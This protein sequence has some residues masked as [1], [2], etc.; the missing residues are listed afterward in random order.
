[1]AEVSDRITSLITQKVVEVMQAGSNAEM[2]RLVDELAPV[3]DQELILQV[4]TSDAL[5]DPDSPASG[6]SR[7]V[8]AITG[9]RS[10]KNPVRLRFSESNL[11][12]GRFVARFCRSQEGVAPKATLSRSFAKNRVP[13][14]HGTESSSTYLVV[15]DGTRHAESGSVAACG[16]LELLVQAWTVKHRSLHGD[17]ANIPEQVKM[18]CERQRELLELSLKGASANAPLFS[19]SP[20]LLDWI[21]RLRG[22]RESSDIAGRSSRNGKAETIRCSVPS[23]AVEI[24]V[25]TQRSESKKLPQAYAL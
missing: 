21:S 1:M 5:V 7:D 8:K 25:D 22:S 9:K 20:P 18:L 24:V 6:V 12:L 11:R 15:A 10:W 17:F 16:L 23:E 4:M 3:A 13:S 19:P 14:G 2:D